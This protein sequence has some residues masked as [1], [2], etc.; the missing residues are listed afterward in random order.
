MRPPTPARGLWGMA[1]AAGLSRDTEM[2]K[3]WRS[4][5]PAP[6]RGE[7]LRR[8]AAATACR[9]RV[10]RCRPMARG[11]ATSGAPGSCLIAATAP[12]GTRSRPEH[13]TGHGTVCAGA[14]RSGAAT[15]RRTAA[16]PPGP[17]AAGATGSPGTSRRRHRPRRRHT[18]PER[19]RR[20]LTPALEAECD[21][22]TIDP[23]LRP[24]NKLSRDARQATRVLPATWVE[25]ANDTRVRVS[26]RGN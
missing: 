1:E 11:H 14:T 7:A 26:K 5:A 6:V 8:F 22:A 23:A 9:L 18:F 10:A 16:T 4:L 20:A 19:F 3:L 21:A 25:R 13:L 12:S 15:S 17:G 24:G 2:G